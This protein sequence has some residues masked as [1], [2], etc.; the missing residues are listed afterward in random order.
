MPPGV[1]IHTT[2]SPSVSQRT[3]SRPLQNASKKYSCV[4]CHTRKVKC[5][6]D[7]PCT[8]CLK[9]GSECTY[10]EPPPPRRRMKKPKQSSAARLK[11]YQE[12]LRNHGIDPDID[13][14]QNTPSSDGGN[15]T[16][17]RN[18]QPPRLCMSASSESRQSKELEAKSGKLITKCGKSMYIEK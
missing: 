5:D 13:F 12:V 2:E 17:S 4:T 10:T 16:C 14:S 18:S 6:R 9:T 7:Q 1:T 3:R 11:R 15:K 8:S